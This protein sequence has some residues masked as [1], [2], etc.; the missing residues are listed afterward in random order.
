MN[1]KIITTNDDVENQNIIINKND[2]NKML[3]IIYMERLPQFIK[4]N[5]NGSISQSNK[6]K[7]R[8]EYGLSFRGKKKNQQKNAILNLAKQIRGGNK[9]FKNVNFAYRFL[10]DVYNE[11]IE[12]LR[13][14]VLRRRRVRKG[15]LKIQRIR[16]RTI[17]RNLR[18][19]LNR[20]KNNQKNNHN[21][22]RDIIASIGGGQEEQQIR[23]GCGIVLDILVEIFQDQYAL[24]QVFR[25]DMV[26]IMSYTLTP[27]NIIRLKK[28]IGDDLEEE[29]EGVSVSDVE[30]FGKVSLLESINV[31]KWKPKKSDKLKSGKIKTS[32][33]G[34][35]FKHLNN[36][37]FDLSRYGVFHEV[38]KDN[39]KINCLVRSLEH[40]GVKD[41]K[42][43]LV[44]GFIIKREVPMLKLPIIAEMLDIHITVKKEG[45][46]NG[47]LFHY[48]N[49]NLPPI[50]IGII[51][52]HYFLIEDVDFTMYSLI[53]Y[54]PLMKHYGDVNKIKTI[55]AINNEELWK[56]KGKYKKLK[57]RNTDS[58]T[59]IKYMFD[60]KE[61]Y[62]TKM[63]IN[64][65][66]LNTQF[67]DLIDDDDDLS[68][69]DD[70]TRLIDQ[71]DKNEKE[72]QKRLLNEF[73]N[74]WY[75]DFE[76]FRHNEI[77]N[78]KVQT[79]HR[80]FTA[81][82]IGDK[83][84][85]S[86]EVTK[87]Y[88]NKPRKIKR[89]TPTNKI[90]S[91][92]DDCG[93]L[94]LDKICSLHKNKSIP[95]ELFDTTKKDTIE[96]IKNNCRKKADNANCKSEYTRKKYFDK[97]YNSSIK[98]ID[99]KI[100]KK[101]SRMCDNN[102]LMI[103]HNAGYDYRF[104]QKYLYNIKQI[105]KGNGLMNATADYYYND[106]KYTIEFK[107]SLKLIPMR[108]SQF[109][110]CF[111][112]KQEK[113][114]MPY[115]LYTAESIK[116]GFIK[117]QK[118]KVYLK[119]NYNQFYKNCKKLD[120]ITNIDGHD[121]FD[122]MK[123]C[124]FY[125]MLDCKVLKNGYSTYRNWIL[126]ALDLDIDCCW[127]TA[128]LADKYLHSKGCYEGVSQLSGTP[129]FFIQKCVVGGRTM[130]RD[131]EKQSFD[132]TDDKTDKKSS[133]IQ[134]TGSD[135]KPIRPTGSGGKK[136]AD[137]D[138]VS[139]YPSAMARMDGFLKGT[140]KVL[141]TEQMNKSFLDTIDG[142][143]IKIQIKKVNKHR[144][145]PLMSS[146]N[147]E[148]VRVF[149][150]DMVGEYQYVDKVTL[151][152][153][154]EF[155]DIEYDIIKGY[156]YDEGRNTTIKKVIQYLFNERLKKKKEKNPIQIVY[157][158]IM[159]ASYGKTIL[160]PITTDELVIS[161]EDKFHKYLIK[162]YN[163][164]IELNEMFECKKY[165]VKIH[166]S[167]N[168]HFNYASCGVEILSMSKRIMN[169]VMCLA[170]DKEL[171]I[172]YQDTD[173]LHM[174]Y[175]DVAILKKE[176][177]DKYG[178]EL[179]GKKLGQ[180]HIDFD[181]HDKDGNECNNVYAEK[182]IFLGKKCYLD[183]LVGDIDGRIVRGFHIRMKGVPSSTVKYTAEKMGIGLYE[184]YEKLYN[185]N[186]I[187]FDLLEGGG[188][189]NFKFHND[190]SISSMDSF[191]RDLCFVEDMEVRKNLTP[192]NLD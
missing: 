73:R 81:C 1:N 143:F 117:M 191:H 121:C 156:Y 4:I 59:A 2:K 85:Y 183:C 90:V 151:E 135:G 52:K 37:S 15:Q 178:R 128:S 114:V 96:R 27:T 144:H 33:G 22:T 6:R 84:K 112:L 101:L 173:S 164:I 75:F 94:L 14:D 50:N 104:L 69:D 131:N 163:H 83:Y 39:Y 56:K 16:G 157:K 189:C 67:Y 78:N 26:N 32:N 80:P 188:R 136:M 181:L 54:E 145:F 153:Y 57:N 179:D 165:R 107:D 158:L 137:Y 71:E 159:N 24:L 186:K 34:G 139:L 55:Y 23:K 10:A 86:T 35:F 18:R 113:E 47:K 31:F 115:G 64:N 13:E 70:N 177:T 63:K 3:S 43:K 77:V 61:D 132:G 166:K 110:K 40:G 160:K 118:A 65:D 176:F 172:F 74:K 28:V 93:K 111:N 20:V 182:S 109:G 17:L 126:E 30:T 149:T 100:N 68:Y 72:E 98:D 45:S 41:E 11:Q 25:S 155:Q 152:D 105:T 147:K 51:D 122:C 44:K 29:E 76:T 148:G 133:N 184:L 60:N 169:E 66:V 53:N 62:L 174:D 129:Q 168:K 8:K 89:K 140:P 171:K 150:N 134:S 185:G 190:G 48:G 124:E 116:N 108:L 49:Q 125:C 106:I 82:A 46:E 103:A 120:I 102:I 88:N 87:S 79:I 127:T 95:K 36:T 97:L 92:G 192:I 187:R 38:D 154:I 7:L 12:I 99:Q 180:F 119:D 123:Y 142:Y 170:E 141:K 19:E 138:G 167:I 161:G 91:T 162:N 130:M 146:I 5:N 9:K 21:I 58:Y 42:L 175:D